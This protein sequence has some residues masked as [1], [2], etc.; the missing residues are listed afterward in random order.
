MQNLV[1]VMC[2]TVYDCDGDIM[3]F[4]KIRWRWGS[5]LLDG[6]CP[7]NARAPRVIG[8][9]YLDDYMFF[10]LS[11]QYQSVTDGQSSRI[12]IVRPYMLTRDLKKKRK[13]VM[14]LLCVF[15]R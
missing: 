4:K 7:G 6:A 12:S 1:A 11:T 13:M 10:E 15:E 14:L 3:R 2:H 8:R 9:H 5:A